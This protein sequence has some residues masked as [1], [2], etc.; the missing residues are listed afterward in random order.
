MC[1][2]YS[3]L[4]FSLCGLERE[5]VFRLRS[6]K[7]YR[8]QMSKISDVMGERLPIEKPDALIGIAFNI[9]NAV[10]RGGSYGNQIKFTAYVEGDKDNPFIFF[11]PENDA[12]LL[13]VNHFKSTPDDEI[14]DV[15]LWQKPATQKG[16]SPSYNFCDFEKFDPETGKPFE[17]EE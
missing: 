7:G 3:P 11:L 2:V 4:A 12:R 15:T 17:I 9:T 14:T 10:V 5:R 8:G 1:G 13:I 16:R 6:L